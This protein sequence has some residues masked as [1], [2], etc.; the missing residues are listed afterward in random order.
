MEPFLGRQ[1]QSTLSKRCIIMQQLFVCKMHWYYTILHNSS[2]TAHN[3]CIITVF[4][5]VQLITVN[6]TETALEYYTKQTSTLC[7]NFR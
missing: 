3:K 5:T 4:A 1:S 2:T 6:Y 7:E